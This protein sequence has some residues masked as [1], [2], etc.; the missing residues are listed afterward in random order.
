MLCS[1]KTITSFSDT[2]F[3]ENEALTI[4]FVR[5]K[6]VLKKEPP[7]KHGSD[8]SLLLFWDSDF[9]LFSAD[10]WFYNIY[11]RQQEKSH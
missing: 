7:L 8:N 2:C 5:K 6:S 10:A 1:S 9:V 3:W 4:V 11:P